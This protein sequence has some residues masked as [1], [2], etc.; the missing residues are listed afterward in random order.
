[1]F[2]ATI[3]AIAIAAATSAPPTELDAS[4]AV[5]TAIATC[6]E[7]V[8]NPS[9]WVDGVTQFPAKTGLGSRGLV[10][11]SSLPDVALPPPQ[12]RRAMHHW[13][14]PIGGGGVFV[15][16][17]DELPVCHLSGGGPFDLQPSVVKAQTSAEFLRHWNVVRTDVKGN[18]LTT[19]YQSL[20][21]PK[22]SLILTRSSKAGDRT[23]RVQI[24][25]TA[26]YDT[27]K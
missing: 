16:T 20:R 26:Q 27:G 4:A 1:M 17:S 7:W 8:L 24:V 22:L 21:D 5:V 3:A 23:D 15:T 19:Y 9:S 11:Q 13:R 6:E 25:A 12:F 10:P 2:G 18:L 14:V